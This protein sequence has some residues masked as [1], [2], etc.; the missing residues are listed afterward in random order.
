[1]IAVTIAVS[2]LF[3]F[4]YGGNTEYSGND[5]P[6]TLMLQILKRTLLLAV[7]WPLAYTDY[8]TYRIPNIFIILG[9]I[10]RVIILAFEFLFYNL[11]TALSILLFDAIA[12][13]GLLLASFLCGLI[14]KNSIGM[15][16]MKLFAI[17]GLMLGMDILSSVFV[18]LLIAFIVSIVL[19]ISKKKTKK[20]MIP[21]GP[22]VVIGTFVSIAWSV[23]PVASVSLT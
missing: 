11:E 3:V 22:C 13:A 19:L 1:M 17:M 15:G 4:S 5:S 20:D 21:F 10:I 9:L 18:S 6:Q 12:A 8:K 16:D 14:L 23:V 2:V 7:I